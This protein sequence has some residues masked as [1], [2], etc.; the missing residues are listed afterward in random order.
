[1]PFSI[2]ARSC[3]GKPLALAQVMLTMARLFWEFDMRR[4]DRD[5]SEAKD[6]EYVVADHVT[7]GG[8]GPMLS[9]RRG[10][11]PRQR[12]CDGALIVDLGPF[13]T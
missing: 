5:D 4:V 9:F 7:A 13:P 11:N 8:Q 3:I 1:M 6:A 2:G 12:L 10:F